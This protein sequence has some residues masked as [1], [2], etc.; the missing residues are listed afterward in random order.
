[1]Y[2]KKHLRNNEEKKLKKYSS[3]K[4]AHTQVSLVSLLDISIACK[5]LSQ[6]FR[7]SRVVLTE[8]TKTLQLFFLPD[9]DREEIKNL[10][11][12]VVEHKKNIFFFFTIILRFRNNAFS[13]M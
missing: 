13:L 11:I 3:C 8:E 9:R 7:V 12:L 5:L 1:M 10:K 2:E 6:L 4:Q